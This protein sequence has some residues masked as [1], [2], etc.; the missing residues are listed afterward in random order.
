M[1]YLGELIVYFTIEIFKASFQVAWDII[2]PKNKMEA[3]VIA[4]PLDVRTNLEITVLSS[5]ISLTPGTLC[6]DIS[7]DRSHLFVHAMYIHHGDVERLK[8]ELKDGFER[9][10]IRIFN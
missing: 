6:I 9:R 10:V 3:G 7:E 5:L 1:I 2:T 4:V 8:Q